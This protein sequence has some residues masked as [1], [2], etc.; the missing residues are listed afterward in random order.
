MYSLLI[1]DDENIILEGLYEV[2]KDAGMPFKEIRTASSAAEALELYRKSPFDV[3]LTDISMPQMDG[4]EMV[5][6]MRKIWS[7]T[8]VIFLTGFQD[9]NYAREALRLHGFDYLLKPM[10]DEELLARL[11][12]V[13]AALDRRQ[14]E[15][16]MFDSMAAAA[17]RQKTEEISTILAEQMRRGTA[18][19]QQLRSS[20]FPFDRERNIRVLVF[21]ADI[22]NIRISQ[23][24]LFGWLTKMLQ[25]I[26]YGY[27]LV[28]GMEQADSMFVFL[29]QKAADSEEMFTGVYRALEEMQSYLYTGLDIRF[30]LLVSHQ[31]GWEGWAQLA[32]QMV[33]EAKS[34]GQYGALYT[35]DG[36]QGKQDRTADDSGNLLIRRI[37]EY[38]AGHPGE[39]LS[40]GRL[41]GMFHI[42]PSYL[43]RSFHQT[44]GQPLSQYIT[45]VR[46]ETAKRLLNEE[47]L[48]IGEISQIVGFETPGYFTKVFNKAVGMTP[49]EYRMANESKK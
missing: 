6:Q 18:D 24:E 11:S 29:V 42:N 36:D 10:P 22:E 7:G 21:A 4:L 33:K 9:F 48:K 2:I 28:Y 17:S 40:L 15:N 13:I 20:V 26:T 37:R 41:A 38:V 12:D 44:I 31:T 16:F 27:G 19:F 35:F 8:E 34:Y 23:E 46:L 14:A 49:K 30:T 39:D 32:R 25:Q 47:N 43:S 5:A 1:V 45:G 3:L